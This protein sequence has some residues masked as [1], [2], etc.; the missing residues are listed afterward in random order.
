M[1]QVEHL[2]FK[3]I[4]DEEQIFKEPERYEGLESKNK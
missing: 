3:S 1:Y 4:S 2:E